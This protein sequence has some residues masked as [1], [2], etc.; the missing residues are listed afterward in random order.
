MKLATSLLACLVVASPAWAQSDKSANTETRGTRPEPPM[1]G[2]HLAKGQNKPAP[3]NGL[4]KRSPNLIY[5]NGPVIVTTAEVRPIFWGTKWTDSAFVLDKID[6]VN[7]FYA[8]ANNSA[9]MSSNTEYTQTGGAHVVKTVTAFAGV[10]DSSAG[11]TKAPATSTILAEACKMI[12]DNV[13]TNGYY[14][15]Y[16]DVPRGNAGYC[17]WHSWGSCTKS[18]GSVVN[19]QFAFFFNL[20]GDPGCDPQAGGA[21]SQGLSALANVSGHELSE[22]MTDPRGNAWF[23]NSGAENSDK[24]AWTFGAPFLTFPNNTTWKIQGN[25]S[26]AAYNANQGYVDGSKVRG[27]IDGEN[28]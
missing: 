11:P 3:P 20:D 19:V 24:C 23:D 4:G 5:H 7:L 26:N 9:Y 2:K 22:F 27:C 15:V 18:N 21:H 17:A 13:K 8:G 10:V 12:G 6:G 1:L 25:W 16:V 28:P 14:P